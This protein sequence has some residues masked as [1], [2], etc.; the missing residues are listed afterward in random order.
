MLWYFCILIPFQCFDIVGWAKQEGRVSHLSVLIKQFPRVLCSW[1]T[2]PNREYCQKNRPVKQKW[3]GVVV[4]VV[5][6]YSRETGKCQSGS[7]G[8]DAVRDGSEA[9]VTGGA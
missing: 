7:A 3:N 2:W 6:L 5:L 9:E 8:G 1:R 4:V